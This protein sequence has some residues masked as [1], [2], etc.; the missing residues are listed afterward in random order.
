M[1]VLK[2]LYPEKE[3]HG[4]IAYVDRS[5]PRKPRLVGG[6]EGHIIKII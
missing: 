4:V 6:V 1:N 5:V 2:G 3:I